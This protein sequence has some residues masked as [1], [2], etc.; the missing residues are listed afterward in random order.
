MREQAMRVVARPRPAPAFD[1][2][3][4]ACDEL[5]PRLEVAAPAEPG[6]GRGRRRFPGARSSR[7][8]KLASESATRR[9]P[10]EGRCA[11]GRRRSPC[12]S[13]VPRALERARLMWLRAIASTDGGA[14][15]DAQS[16]ARVRADNGTG[17][18]FRPSARYTARTGFCSALTAPMYGR[19]G[20]SPSFSC[21]GRA[22]LV[23]LLQIRRW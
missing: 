23:G 19:P 6:A 16:K 5:L 21:P 1:R 2:E 10:I 15:D 13:R 18:G 20:G 8:A 22:E 7:L 4:P 9:S 14:R 11:R 3:Q 12:G 17:R